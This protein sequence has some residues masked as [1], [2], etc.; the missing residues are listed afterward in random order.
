MEKRKAHYSLTQLKGLLKNEATR[1]ITRTSLKDAN[2]LGFSETEIIDTILELKQT[3]FY[4]AMTTQ[5][6]TRTWQDVY[7]TSENNINLYIKLQISDNDEGV[8]VSFKK[9]EGGEK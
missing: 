6:N 1:V 4:K 7:K 8:V 5:Q 9:D 3:N 2:G